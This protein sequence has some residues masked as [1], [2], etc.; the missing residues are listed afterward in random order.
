MLSKAAA[1][2]MRETQVCRARYCKIIIANAP[3]RTIRQVSDPS[4]HPPLTSIPTTVLPPG[5]SKVARR[6]METMIPRPNNTSC[7]KLMEAVSKL[8]VWKIAC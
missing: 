6:M 1:K 8:G 2:M 4:I 3:K 5:P 7:A